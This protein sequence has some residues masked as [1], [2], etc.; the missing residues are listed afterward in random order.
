MAYFC[1]NYTLHVHTLL[2][3][4]THTHV[5]NITAAKKSIWNGGLLI[6]ILGVFQL[7]FSTQC[8]LKMSYNVKK[9]KET[10]NKSQKNNQFP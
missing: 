5:N 7:L 10:N 8:R 1:L 9:E 4:H 2:C 3:T 6:F